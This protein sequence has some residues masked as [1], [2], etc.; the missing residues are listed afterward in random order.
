MRQTE[1]QMAISCH[2]MNFHYWDWVTANCPLGSHKNPQTTQ[3][4]VKDIGCSP[5]TDKKP[6]L[7]K[8]ISTQLNEHGEV[9]LLPRQ[10]LHIY[11]L[12]SLVQECT[13]YTT[14]RERNTIPVT[15][16]LLYNH[17]LHVR[18]ATSIER[19]CNIA[20][21]TKSQRLAIDSSGT[22]G[23]IKYSIFIKKQ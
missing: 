7:L 12:V 8:G 15:K 18:Y 1:S 19:I 20:W 4:V 22:Q 16:P 13:L 9:K 10:S 23:K 21:V 14:K 17:V 2:Q 11:T 3:A 5:Q 6:S